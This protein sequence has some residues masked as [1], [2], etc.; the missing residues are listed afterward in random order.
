VA[1]A[2]EALAS[3]HG[4]SENAGLY[5]YKAAYYLHLQGRN[6]EALAYLD[7]IDESQVEA[8]LAPKIRDLRRSIR[9]VR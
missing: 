4:D 7:L 1:E 9:S 8:D 6:Q 5:R 3:S 2:Y